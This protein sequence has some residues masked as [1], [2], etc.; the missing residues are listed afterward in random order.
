MRTLFKI[1]SLVV[2]ASASGALA[3]QPAANT[4]SKASW[5]IVTPAQAEQK[6]Y[7]DSLITDRKHHG[8][9]IHPKLLYSDVSE[10]NQRSVCS[11]Y[12]SGTA[13]TPKG[14]TWTDIGMSF[15]SVCRQLADVHNETVMVMPDPA[16]HRAWMIFANC[17]EKRSGIRT[18]VFS[19]TRV[20]PCLM[21]EGPNLSVVLGKEKHGYFIYVGTT[22]QLGGKGKVSK[23]TVVE[24]KQ[25]V[26]KQNA[27]K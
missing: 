7:L 4:P 12:A 9:L 16:N 11:G 8:N 19:Y 24:V 17:T 6:A 14:S 22:S 3:Q 20:H 15:S 1:A 5:Q 13:D 2:L 25:F 21:Q 26:V 23:Y 10:T 18:S 27:A